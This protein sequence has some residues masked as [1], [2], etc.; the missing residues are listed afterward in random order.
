MSTEILL[1]EMMTSRITS[2]MSASTNRVTSIS[3]RAEKSE[4]HNVEIRKAMT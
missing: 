1:E 4:L 2:L 3:D